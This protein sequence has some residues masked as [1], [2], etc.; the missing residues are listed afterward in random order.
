MISTTTIK[1][2][3][4]IM[5]RPA[6]CVNTNTTL[7]EIKKILATNAI[8]YLPIVDKNKTLFAI[9]ENDDIK[10]LKE[11]FGSQTYHKSYGN[12]DKKTISSVFTKRPLAIGM[13]NTI[14]QCL[15]VFKNGKIN[16]LP[17]LDAH[18]KLKGII[19]NRDIDQ[20]I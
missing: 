10:T 13:N 1:K 3:A 14:P 6:Q 2:A 12:L 9:I 15:E 7:Q 4:N 5:H 18:G 16:A 19:T 8:D 11:I 17:V 20:L